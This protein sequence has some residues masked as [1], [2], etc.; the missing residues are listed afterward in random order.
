MNLIQPSL[1]QQLITLEVHLLHCTMEIRC[2]N[3]IVHNTFIN[4]VSNKHLYKNMNS[5]ERVY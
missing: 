4:I 2:T 5:K 3:M 1:Q